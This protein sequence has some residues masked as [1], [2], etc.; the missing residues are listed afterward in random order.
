MK[1]KANQTM[2]QHPVAGK[3]EPLDRRRLVI[4]DVGLEMK[5]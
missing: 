2:H 4:A 3:Q 5:T 1:R